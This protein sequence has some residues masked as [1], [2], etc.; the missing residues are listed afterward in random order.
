MGAVIHTINP[1]LFEPQIMHILDHAEDR[2]LF[3]DL[4]FMPLV[5]RLVSSFGTERPPR[6][7]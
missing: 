3:V 1:R 4:T 7:L 2:V 6:W 5:G